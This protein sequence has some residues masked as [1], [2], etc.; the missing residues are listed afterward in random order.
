[1]K[2]TKENQKKQKNASTNVQVEIQKLVLARLK[3]TSRDFQLSVGS[4]DYSTQELIEKV[5]EGG[6]IGKQIMEI[7][8]EYLRNLSSGKIYKYL[9]DE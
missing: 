1:M 7:Q 4:K 2:Q 3:A 9:D 6:E 5:K 8:M